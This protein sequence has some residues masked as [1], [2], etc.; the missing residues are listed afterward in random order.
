MRKADPLLAYQKKR[1]FSRTPEPAANA[2]AGGKGHSFVVQKHW[3][4]HL[5][6][7]FRLEL[8]GVMK[9]WAVPKGPSFD[10]QDKR[11][12][13]Q[14]EDH[15]LSYSGFEGEIPEKQYGAG[16]V[17]IW[18]KGFWRPL[19]EPHKGY[20]GGNLKFE[21]FGHKLQGR[22]VLVRMKSRSERQQ[23]WLLIK[24]K[25][26]YARPGLKFS[27]VD[28]RPESVARLKMPA[29]EKAAV[30]MKKPAPAPRAALP[31]TLT[32]Q[33]A[34]LVENPPADPGEWVFELKLDGYRL[35]TRK[36]R[37]GIRFFTRNGNDWTSKLAVL[38][39]EV[40]LLKLPPGW[41]DGELVMPDAR[42]RPDFGALQQAFDS[43]R[44]A[45][46]VL[47]L[48][49]VPFLAGRDL[50]QLPLLERRHQ[51][52][53]LL[54]GKSTE[55]VRLSEEF[56]ASPGDLVA[57]ACKL[58]LEG[59]IGKRKAS[60]YS[61]RR[62]DDWIKLKC[63]QRQEFVIAGFTEPKG[64]RSDLGALLLG[65]HDAAGALRYA[66]KVGTGFD[67]RT[68][69]SLKK[70][71]L[72]RRTGKS[73]FAAGEKI[74]DKPHWVQPEL[75]AEVSFGNW[76]RDGR[77]R[78]SVFHALRTDKPAQEIVREK[79]ARTRAA[80]KGT[81]GAD[82]LSV[83][84]SSFRITHPDRIIDAASGL[85]KIDLVRYYGLV[86]ALMMEHLKERP[87]ALVR[88]P[89]GVQGPLFFQKHAE[90]ERL[91]GVRTLDPELDR[92]HAPML[93]VQ[94]PE[95]LV[96]AAQWN[97][98][99]FHTR[100]ALASAFKTPDRMIFD[101]DP[102]EGVHW[103]EVR[104][105]AELLKRFLDE[106]DLPAFL[107]TSGGK[108]LH[109]VVPLRPEFD[110]DTVKAFSKS[111]TVHLARVIPQRFVSISGP[112][113][114]RGRIFIDYLRNGESSTTACAWS[115]RARPGMGISVPVAWE[116]LAKLKSAD[117]WTVQ[118]VHARLDVGNAPWT[119]YR[120]SARSLKKAIA[121]LK[122][123]QIQRLASRGVV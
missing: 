3:A 54:E 75:I 99:E 109:V 37:S 14:V 87:V 60:G 52:Q 16:K 74:G 57:S 33:L 2:V 93:A 102:G 56:V 68:L 103:P 113:N 45:E 104:E 55:S 121:R 78:H 86:G 9:S 92:G 83:L 26:A 116:E 41:Y 71:L 24:E 95:G 58:G 32:P 69:A 18:D 112:K 119:N 96:S 70:K 90:T 85:R 34:T 6:Y 79:P 39:R 44:T 97:V 61:S 23:P 15:P 98:V 64:S 72:A 30:S 8:D 27:V 77:I 120:R 76:P 35:L 91:P 67:Q 46:L 80:G 84:S 11:M 31:A 118:S 17:I 4:S 13:V 122:M 111:I 7:D 51:L 10:P 42:G 101:L 48:F 53:G 59:I 22:W 47:Y 66:G 28:E 115:A 40:A 62:S 43:G 36:D 25:D 49:D 65:V 1:D 19:A 73:P 63:S 29:F 21:L 110:W 114:R 106:L 100:N 50:R 38:K 107:K 88:A 117:Q 5:H 89:T 82:Q 94:S 81:P 123:V 12:A 108:G 20:R 105:A